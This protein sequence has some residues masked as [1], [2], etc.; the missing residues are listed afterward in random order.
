MI[1]WQ[2]RM[3][4]S[5]I[6]QLAALAPESGAYMNEVRLPQTWLRLLLEG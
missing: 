6:P 4:E 5:Y 1:E 2:V 3:P